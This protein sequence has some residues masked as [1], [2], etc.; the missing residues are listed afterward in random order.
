MV[1]GSAATEVELAPVVRK[2]IGT[3]D[4]RATSLTNVRT[5]EEEPKSD[6]VSP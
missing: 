4:N 3:A 6:Q 1:V 5:D 2:R